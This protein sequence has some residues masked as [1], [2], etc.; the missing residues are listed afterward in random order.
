MSHLEYALPY[1]LL[2]MFS[3]QEYVPML[4][5]MMVVAPLMDFFFYVYHDPSCRGMGRLLFNP[6]A[7]N[8]LYRAE[9]TPISMVASSILLV[10]M[11]GAAHDFDE[12]LSILIPRVFV[13]CL[14]V[15]NG[16]LKEDGWWY[17]GASILGYLLDSTLH[18]RDDLSYDETGLCEYLFYQPVVNDRSMDRQKMKSPLARPWMMLC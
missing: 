9:K 7:M 10:Q 17:I 8:A 2:F 14:L 3:L 11:R 18:R 4:M 1:L 12:S 13:L 6:L 16:N 15:V 5:T